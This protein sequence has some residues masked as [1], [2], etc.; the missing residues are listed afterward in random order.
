MGSVKAVPGS[1]DIGQHYHSKFRLVSEKYCGAIHLHE[2]HLIQFFLLATHGCGAPASLAALHT[3]VCLDIHAAA[4]I[5][6]TVNFIL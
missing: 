1:T 3:T 2:N 4:V 6:I 5:T